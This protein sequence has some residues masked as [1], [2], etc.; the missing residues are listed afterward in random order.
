MDDNHGD[1]VDALR[2]AG[3]SV[4]STAGLGG[5]FPDLCVGLMGRNVLFEVKDGA[6]VPS[7]RKLTKDE[8]TWRAEWRG[9]VYTVETVAEAL[10]I[11]GDIRRGLR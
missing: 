4:T 10:A 7:K 2:H 1:I 5:G 9:E 8:A 11:V 3:C 6:K